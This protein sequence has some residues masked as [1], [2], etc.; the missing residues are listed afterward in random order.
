MSDDRSALSTTSGLELIAPTFLEHWALKRK[1]SRQHTTHS[2]VALREWRRAAG[3]A[4][5]VICGLAGSLVT[6]LTPGTVFIPE[7]ARLEDGSTVVCDPAFTMALVTAARSLGY[8]LDTRPLLTASGLITGPERQRWSSKSF[9][10]AD[11]ETALLANTGLRVATVRVILDSPTHP[12]S[13]EWIQPARAALRPGAWRDLGW[14]AW[15]GPRFAL[16]AAEV[17]RRG[18]P[19]LSLAAS[20]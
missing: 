12:I 19:E 14:L 20:S 2:G 15:N 5:V 8:R 11:M 18:L 4:G 17:L 13:Q 7:V 3:L 9:V 6:D 16:R 10:A 1:L